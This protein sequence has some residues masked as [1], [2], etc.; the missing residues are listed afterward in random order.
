MKNIILYLFALL[1]TFSCE[2]IEVK[3]Q[4]LEL[5]EFNIEINST[6]ESI[7]INE[8]I[9]LSLFVDILE[10]KT[11]NLKFSMIC[12]DTGI[13]GVFSVN[14]VNYADGETID[15]ISSG[16]IGIS[17][18]GTE[19]G[20]G[21]LTFQVE[22]S[23][24]KIKSIDVPLDIQRTDFDFEILFSKTENYVNELTDFSININ[25]NTNENLTYKTYFKNIE[26]FLRIGDVEVQSNKMVEVFNGTT[27]GDFRATKIQDSEIEFF[28][29]ASNGLMRKRKVS[30][31]SLPTDFEVIINPT[32]IRSFFEYNNSFF[33][34]NIIKPQVSNQS[35]EY[36]MFY[37]NNIGKAIS[38]QLEDLQDIDGTNDVYDF[39]E[40]TYTRGRISQVGTPEPISGDITFFFTDSNGIKVTKT[41]S[42]EF[43]DNQ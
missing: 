6:T 42:L 22:A 21:S 11:E 38:I 35:L 19:I 31:N 30:F 17:Y 29:T 16:N 39:K 27:F 13:N 32:P 15:N 28:I 2:E 18:I 5:T 4:E 12:Y 10:P 26:G 43:Y 40:R 20:S 41:V 34:I 7:A 14:G 33:D 24:G 37:D 9:E 3:T 23:N 8:T 36:T 1:I 25:Q